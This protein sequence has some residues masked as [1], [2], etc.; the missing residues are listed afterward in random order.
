MAD[1]W[2]NLSETADVLGVHPST[3]RNWSN[4]GLLPVHRTQ[5]GHRRYRRSEMELWLQSKRAE[6]PSEMRLVAQNTLRSTRFHISE[7]RLHEEAWYNKLDE[8][9]RDQYRQSGRTMLQGLIQFINSE[10]K[11]TSEAESIGYEYASRGRRFGMNS[12]EATQ[13]FLFFRNVLM[14]SMLD[15][16]DSAAIHSVDSWNDMYHKITSFTDKIL[17]TILET[18]EVYQRGSR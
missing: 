13:A 3:V 16:L 14:E 11:A 9:A 8:E 2:M 7:G 1:E 17:I 18:Y 10:E 12:A 15:V 6:G 4:Q 5:G